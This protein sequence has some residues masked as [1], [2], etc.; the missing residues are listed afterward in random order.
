MEYSKKIDWSNLNNIT[1][2]IDI[3]YERKISIEDL[4]SN[5]YETYDLSYLVFITFNQ[6]DII[7]SFF[8]LIK[9]EL[10]KKIKIN[11]IKDTTYFYNSM[12]I[13]INNS[14]IDFHIKQI[15]EIIGYLNFDS[16]GIK[17]ELMNIPKS[18]KE[19]I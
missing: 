13:Q 11:I 19:K 5:V 6:N 8:K 9:T 10:D 7:K 12:V 17:Y 1:S 2:N 14:E 15:L 16:K 4:F 18:N 3:L